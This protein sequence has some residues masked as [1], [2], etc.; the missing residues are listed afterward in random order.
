[1]VGLRDARKRRKFSLAV[2]PVPLGRTIEVVIVLARSVFGQAIEHFWR[3]GCHALCDEFPK[4]DGVASWC[5]CLAD[6][7][8]AEER[9][10]LPPHRFGDRDHTPVFFAFA[11]MNRH[12]MELIALYYR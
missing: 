10:M 5:R 1:M 11:E 6:A 2:S 9:H 12:E 3:Q 8:L 4:F 7:G